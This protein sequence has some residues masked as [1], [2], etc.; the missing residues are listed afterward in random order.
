MSCD[1]SHDHCTFDHDIYLADSICFSNAQYRPRLLDEACRF[2]HWN[3]GDETARAV[4]A[5]GSG[6]CC[7]LVELWSY[8]HLCLEGTQNGVVLVSRTNPE[9]QYEE[10]ISGMFR[11]VCIKSSR[12][13]LGAI[14]FRKAVA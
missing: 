13:G 2:G 4:H 8:H 1:T 3:F 10:Q 12:I 9:Y 14:I 6:T 11:E 5:L 7:Y